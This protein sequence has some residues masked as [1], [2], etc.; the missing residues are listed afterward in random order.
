LLTLTGPAVEVI[1]DLTTAP[2]MA[3]K[4][5]LRIVHSDGSGSLTLT[6]EAEPEHGDEIVETAGVRVFLQGEV[7]EMLDGH[8]LDAVV[9]HR[10]VAFRVLVP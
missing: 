4:S 5:G 7:A 10:G 6:V 8:C 3:E 1:R 9:D 2:G